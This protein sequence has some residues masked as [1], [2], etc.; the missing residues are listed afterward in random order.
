MLD[1]GT[2]FIASVERKPDALAFVDGSL[3]LTYAQSYERISA[4]S[5]A[6]TSSA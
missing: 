5:R 4:W 6:S 2:S 3:R 1:L